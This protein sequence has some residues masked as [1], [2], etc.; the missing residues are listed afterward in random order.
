MQFSMFYVFI[1]CTANRHYVDSSLLATGVSIST[2]LQGTATGQRVVDIYK[3]LV[4]K[5]VRFCYE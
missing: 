5:N 1:G 2:R 4:G 3:G